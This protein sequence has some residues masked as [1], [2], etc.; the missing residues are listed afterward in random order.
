MRSQPGLGQLLY[1]GGDVG[2]QRLSYCRHD[3]GSFSKRTT[4]VPALR[5]PDPTV[6]EKGVG[7]LPVL[8]GGNSGRADRRDAG[9]GKPRPL[10]GAFCLYPDRTVKPAC[11]RG[12]DECPFRQRHHVCVHTTTVCASDPLSGALRLRISEADSRPKYTRTTCNTRRTQRAV[13]CTRGDEAV[14]RFPQ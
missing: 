8:R 9:A 1:S 12:G 13:S 2:W 4:H 6:R 14:M 11:T 7:A 3:V 5:R 10:A